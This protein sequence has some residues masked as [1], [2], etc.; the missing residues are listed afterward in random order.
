[1]IHKSQSETTTPSI[2]EPALR[3]VGSLKSTIYKNIY[4]LSMRE[5]VNIITVCPLKRVYVD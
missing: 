5:I 2:K 3:S 1:M 4:Y